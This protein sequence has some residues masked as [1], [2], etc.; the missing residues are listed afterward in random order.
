MRSLE[1]A[2]ESI[3]P[4]SKQL[5]STNLRRLKM[6]MKKGAQLPLP[7]LMKHPKEDGQYLVFDGHHR[8]YLS[9]KLTPELIR[10]NIIENV[11]D[12]LCYDGYFSVDDNNII[13]EEEISGLLRLRRDRVKEG[14]ISVSDIPISKMV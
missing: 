7:G 5:S 14:I 11:Q 2:I 4:T 3:Q 10:V 8:L 9:A 12:V 6:V 13:W 1:L